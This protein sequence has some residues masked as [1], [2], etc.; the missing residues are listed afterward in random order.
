MTDSNK[1]EQASSSALPARVSAAPMSFGGK[2]QGS[3]LFDPVVLP[4]SHVTS[5]CDKH[6]TCHSSTWI[7]LPDSVGG[8]SPT[9]RRTHLS[10]SKRGSYYQLVSLKLNQPTGCPSGS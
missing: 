10:H 3:C 2:V 6:A 7:E 9:R 1:A 4:G 8:R 5:C